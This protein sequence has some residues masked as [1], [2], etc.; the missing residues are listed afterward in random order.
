MNTLNKIRFTRLSSESTSVDP[1]P[2]AFVPGE[3]AT[4]PDLSLARRVP[5][6]LAA[7]D[8]AHERSVTLTPPWI[9]VTRIFVPSVPSGA[10][11]RQ[12]DSTDST[13]LLV[14]RSVEVRQK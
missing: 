2:M 12:S 13:W 8:R 7:A 9:T 5:G 10:T 14:E 4:I 6:H 3:A 11:C 1:M